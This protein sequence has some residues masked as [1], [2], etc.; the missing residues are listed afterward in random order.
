MLFGRRNKEWWSG[1]FY[2]VHKKEYKED[3]TGTHHL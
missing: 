2:N 3:I 1:D